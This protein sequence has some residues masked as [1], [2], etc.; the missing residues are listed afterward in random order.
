M[1]DKEVE[2]NKLAQ[3]I[4]RVHE[5]ILAEIKE[6]GELSYFKED[7]MYI[8]HNLL[9]RQLNKEEKTACEIAV[10]NQKS[11]IQIEKEKHMQEKIQQLNNKINN[12]QEEFLKYDW[13]NANSEQIKNQVKSLYY[14]IFN[15]EKVGSD[16]NEI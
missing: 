16:T 8:I 6:K 14:S 5:H 9:E 4:Y 12:I 11:R 7:V 3:I 13:A 2:N 15:K 10:R 1:L